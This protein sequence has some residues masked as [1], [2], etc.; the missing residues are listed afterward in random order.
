MIANINFFEFFNTNFHIHVLF[1]L[2]LIIYQKITISQFNSKG[3]YLLRNIDI[4]IIRVILIHVNVTIYS[5]PYNN[6]KKMH[7]LHP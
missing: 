2:S 3:E 6:S 7:Q 4:I 5:S 1:N